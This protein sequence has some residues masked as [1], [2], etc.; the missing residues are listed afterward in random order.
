MCLSHVRHTP[1]SDTL[2]R[3]RCH[4]LFAGRADACL[5]YR[6]SGAAT[7]RD[8]ATFAMQEA[9]KAGMLYG[10]LRKLCRS[11]K[12][13]RNADLRELKRMVASCR[14][15][16][17][18]DVESSGSDG[19]PEDTEAESSSSSE[20][21]SDE[22]SSSSMQDGA[23]E[24]LPK[25]S[26]GKAPGQTADDAAAIEAADSDGDGGVNE[27]DVSYKPPGEFWASTVVDVEAEQCGVLW[28]K[29]RPTGTSTSS[30]ADGIQSTSATLVL[31]GT[32]SGGQSTLPW[33]LLALALCSFCACRCF[34]PSFC[35]RR[36]AGQAL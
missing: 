18:K 23:N 34:A 5:D 28:P 7:K 13:A 22:V 12:R 36:L 33:R 10:Y 27:M 29:S 17:L 26:G 8:S 30:G 3:V 32:L 2:K 25:V 14:M 24:P 6:I 19:E 9:V 1:A 20:D 4:F 16:C 11:S 35:P 31:Q 21:A 15:P